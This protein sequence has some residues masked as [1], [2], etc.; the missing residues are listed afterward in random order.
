[1]LKALILLSLGLASAWVPTA[2]VEARMTRARRGGT[3]VAQFPWSK[4][5]AA[6]TKSVAGGDIKSNIA[7]KP[8]DE[9]TEEEERALKLEV[10][11][12]FPPRT[13]TV[14]GQGYQACRTYPL[15]TPPAAGT[16]RAADGSGGAE[17]EHRAA[18]RLHAPAPIA[19]SSSRARHRRRLCRKTFQ[20]SSPATISATWQRP[21]WLRRCAPLVA[22]PSRSSTTVCFTLMRAPCLVLQGL[23]VTMVVGTVALAGFVIAA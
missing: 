19:H 12:N 7:F 9:L 21:A 20:A 5:K 22:L 14:K 11:T 4:N 17:P 3:P 23:I 16:S 15:S 13:S 1:M 18:R 2:R 8:L 10:G 6:P